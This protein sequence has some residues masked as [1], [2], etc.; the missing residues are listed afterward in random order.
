MTQQHTTQQGAVDHV[1][2][3][4]QRVKSMRNAQKMFFRH[5]DITWLQ[6]SKRLESE[7]D[8]LLR[9]AEKGGQL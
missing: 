5:H 8:D 9:H 7:V 1:R 6:E 4:Y 2:Q 3:F